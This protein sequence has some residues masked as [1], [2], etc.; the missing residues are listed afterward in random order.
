MKPKPL[1]YQSMVM[2]PSSPFPRKTDAE[3]MADLIAKITDSCSQSG[4]SI[5][6][7]YICLDIIKNDYRER[8]HK[9]T[10]E[11]LECVHNGGVEQ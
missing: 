5:S 8:I 1:P 11:I 7:C 6:D 10:D 9:I 3:L 4:L 2:G